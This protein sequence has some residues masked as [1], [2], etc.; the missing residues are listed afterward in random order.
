[1][2]KLTS[3]GNDNQYCHIYSMARE[4]KLAREI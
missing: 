2:L 1:M 4:Y 3:M